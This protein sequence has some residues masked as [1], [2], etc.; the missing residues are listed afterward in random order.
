MDATASVEI[1]ERQ[2]HVQFQKR[3]RIPLLVAA[4]Y[5]IIDVPIPWLG[6]IRL[7]LAFG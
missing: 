4:G 6:G 2:I 5:D 3:A 7:R 1:D